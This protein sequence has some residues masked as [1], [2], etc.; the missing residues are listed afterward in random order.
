MCKAD[1]GI[2]VDVP[3][4]DAP[5]RKRRLS[6]VYQSDDELEVDPEPDFGDLVQ[7][8]ISFFPTSKDD[9]IIEKRETKLTI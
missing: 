8:I 5:S 7:C 9:E 3:H 6:D 4:P 1:Y 2:Y